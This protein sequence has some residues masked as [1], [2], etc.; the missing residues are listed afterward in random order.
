[1]TRQP[2]GSRSLTLRSAGTRNSNQY[3]GGSHESRGNTFRFDEDAAYVRH[4]HRP[5]F[6]AV[7]LLQSVTRAGFDIRQNAISLLSLGDLGWIQMANFVITGVLSV[8]CA[9]GVRRVLGSQRAGTWGP[10]LFGGY[11]VGL[12]IAG[13]FPP[14][15]A[16][17]FPPGAPSG[18]P[19]GMSS[20]AALHAVG[21]FVSF[22][23]LIADSFV[24]ARRF[25]SLQKR[26]WVIYCIATGIAAPLLVVLSGLI[27]SWTGVI[28]ALAGAVAF[29]WASA[30]SAR[31]RS[32][33]PK[34]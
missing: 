1:M 10:L 28:V 8:A 22:L 13:L 25:S 21:F 12:I 24:F 19:V 20:H 7:A 14:D 34:A 18:P 16:F 33:L 9:F 17:G 4:R 5:L 31:L 26:G 27:M 15:P 30:T 11:G 6:F 23:S 2:A 3:F 29:G 32:E